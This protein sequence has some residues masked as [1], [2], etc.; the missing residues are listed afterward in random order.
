MQNT[1]KLTA[2]LDKISSLLNSSH[3]PE[4]T[5][6]HIFDELKDLI[7]YDNGFMFF[8][9]G[10]SFSLKASRLYS[11]EIPFAEFIQKTTGSNLK[12]FIKNKDVIIENIQNPTPSALSEL[13]IELKTPYS[14]IMAPFKI[15][16]TIFGALVL[17]KLN[18]N[19]AHEDL[20][21]VE[22][23][24]SVAAY[25]IKDSELSNVFKMQLKALQDSIIE[26]EEANK[27]IKKQNEKILEADRVK[28]EF[29]ANI[30]HELRTP[31][32]AII[33]FSEALKLKL[34]GELNDKQAEYINDIHVSGIH[35]LGMINEI[36]DISKIEAKEMKLYKTDFIA[37]NA[38]NEVINVVTPLAQ[39]KSQTIET[40]FEKNDIK[41]HA[42]YQKLQQILYNLL[43]NAI[44][45]TDQDGK[46]QVGLE[47]KR[48][49]VRIYVKDNG[50]GIDSKY[51]GKIFAKF[52]QI[53]S[54]Y[55]KKE[56]STGLGLTITK[57]LVELHGGKINIESKVNE[58]TT[59]TFEIPNQKA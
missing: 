51:H 42:D 27:T 25:A 50:I 11:E 54:T 15:R 41:I 58:G 44:K 36:L 47:Q 30:S 59:L 10:D 37:N 28:N 5:L 12:N 34:F 23:L 4:Q 24:A 13:G 7:D 2:T 8:L 1:E 45:F 56:S 16:E 35:L 49:A 26:K 57:E 18:K 33:G 53:D 20:K 46:I 52:Q 38:I 43:S 9:Q 39:K 55:T 40:V 32:N 14:Y 6:E 21:I 19:F 48:N 31:L 22:S 3:E 17:T 29:L